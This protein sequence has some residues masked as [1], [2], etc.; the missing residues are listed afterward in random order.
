MSTLICT[1]AAGMDYVTVFQE[2][3]DDQKYKTLHLGFGHKR[4]FPYRLNAQGVPLP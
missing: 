2:T 3:Y 4:I 1:S